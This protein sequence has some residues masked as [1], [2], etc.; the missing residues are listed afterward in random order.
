[1]ISRCDS[2]EARAKIQ[3]T[4]TDKMVKRGSSIEL[5]C[6][7]ESGD[8][9]EKIKKKQSAENID[10]SKPRKKTTA[11]PFRL[12]MFAV[13]TKVTYDNRFLSY[14]CKFT[15]IFAICCFTVTKRY[16]KQMNGKL[17]I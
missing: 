7:V 10:N 4:G 16:L 15:I 17:E 1:M 6:T 9:V 11:G 5:N 2:S 13:K 8:Q 3:E 14:K 12:E